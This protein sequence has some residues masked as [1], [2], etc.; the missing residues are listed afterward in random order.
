MVEE[1][2]FYTWTIIE[3]WNWL[4]DLPVLGFAVLVLAGIYVLFMPFVIRSHLLRF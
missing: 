4:I 1:N 2:P 3:A